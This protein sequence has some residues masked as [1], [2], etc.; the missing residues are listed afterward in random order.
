MDVKAQV[1]HS[2]TPPL[3]RSVS[4]WYVIECGNNKIAATTRCA[5]ATKLILDVKTTECFLIA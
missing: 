3:R 2:R 1:S 4:A 5:D